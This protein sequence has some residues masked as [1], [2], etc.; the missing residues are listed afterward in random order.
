MLAGHDYLTAAEVR[1]IDPG[2]DWS[3]CADGSRQESAVKGAVDE[4]AAAHGLQ[5]QR[6]TKETWPSWFCFKQNTDG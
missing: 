2:Q 4:F 5:V 3:V 1:V 6:T